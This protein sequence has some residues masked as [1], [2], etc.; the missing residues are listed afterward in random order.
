MRR[1]LIAMCAVVVGWV[2]VGQPT[3]NDLAQWA[4]AHWEA[5]GSGEVEAAV[6]GFAADGGATFLGT[7][8]DGFYYGS[9]VRAAWAQFFAAFPVQGHALRGVVRAVAEASLV[10][11]TV[12]FAVSE[13]TVVVDSFLRF[14]PDGQI[15]AA[16]YVV[17]W[18]GTPVPVTD[19]AIGDGEYRQSAE[20]P[21]SGATL[22]WR[23]GLV[24]LF[25]ALRSPGTGWVSAGFD[26]VNRM[27]GANYII[28]AVTPAGIAIEDHFGTGT[29]SHRRDARDDVLRAAGTVSGGQTVVEFVIPLDSDDPE[30]KSLVPG[31][32][33]TV[34]LA[35]HR[36]S[37]SF[38]AI[39]TARGS[40][41]MELEN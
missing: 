5:V 30:D 13:G 27:Q 38:T 26:P 31:K 35:Y 20:D 6:A 16:D 1:L 37:T 39:H 3:G 25:A 40:I 8:W 23:N 24:V 41:Q 19:G 14:S 12:E 11:G 22:F 21:R 18:S 32:A 10:Y 7:G 2:A 34:L 9:D 29:T 17:A 36:S 33:Y 28:A 4:L 15:R